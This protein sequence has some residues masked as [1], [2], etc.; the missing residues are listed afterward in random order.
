MP[1]LRSYSLLPALLA[2]I[3]LLTCNWITPGS[4][5]RPT[6]SPDGRVL[7]FFWG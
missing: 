4:G 3:A 2:A 7:P 5:S 1:N 6:W